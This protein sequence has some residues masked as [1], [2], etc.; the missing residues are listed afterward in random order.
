MAAN[1]RKQKDTST[2]NRISVVRR[3]INEPISNCLGKLHVQYNRWRD[4]SQLVLNLLLTC[5]ISLYRA[6][7][8]TGLYDIAIIKGFTKIVTD[9][10]LNV[11]TQF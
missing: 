9:M 10:L 8:A 7:I 3:L 11:D 5:Q 2:E 1:Y 4:K 6:H